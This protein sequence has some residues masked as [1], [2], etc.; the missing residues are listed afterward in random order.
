LLYLYLMKSLK[1]LFDFY[2]NSSIHVAFAV[3]AL[4]LITEK[5]LDLELDLYF[6]LFIFLGTITGY[7]FVKYAALAGLHHRNLTDRLKMIQTFSFICFIGLMYVAY[8]FT[9]SF[10]ISCIPL[11]LLTVLYAIP[12]LPH[13]TNLRKVPSI[14]IFIIAA[15]WAGVTVYLPVAYN[16]TNFSTE[17]YLEI[18]QRFMLVL[19]LII[20]FEIRDLTYDSNA[21]GTLPQVL[22]IKKTKL[23]GLSMVLGCMVLE[24]FKANAFSTYAILLL[25]ALAIIRSSSKQ[26]HYYASFAVEG[27]PILWGIFILAF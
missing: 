25:T 8:Q 9:V 20:P 24:A 7:N 18:A 2:I 26:P 12:F 4:A 3:L 10:W 6:N 23:V 11:A 15:V 27:I 16:V 1:G 14:K 5:Q 19:A 21:L 13:K 22:G 17:F